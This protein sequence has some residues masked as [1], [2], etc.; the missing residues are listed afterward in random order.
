MPVTRLDVYTKGGFYGDMRTH[1]RPEPPKTYDE[2]LLW[3]PKEADNSA[4]GQVWVPKGAWGPLGGQM[5]HLSYGRCT[6]MLILRDGSANPPVQ[7]AAVPLPGRFASGVCRGRFHPRD[8][9]LY[10]TGLRGWQTAAVRDGCFQR[11]R[12]QNDFPSPIAYST[13]S[14]AFTITFSEPLDRELAELLRNE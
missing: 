1:H 13:S 14:N 5:L 9:Q 11:V 4:G 10:L 6:M 2:P 7:G 8:H 3:L 12:L